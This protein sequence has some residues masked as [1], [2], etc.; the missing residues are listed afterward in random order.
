[1]TTKE[2]TVKQIEDAKADILKLCDDFNSEDN[3]SGRISMLSDITGCCF[4]QKD[5][6]GNKYKIEYVL[7]TYYRVNQIM[8]FLA[9]LRE[10]IERIETFEN[11]LKKPEFACY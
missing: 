1:M 2:I 3:A 4:G 7:S 10:N 11:R 9:A 5:E 8:V 6:V